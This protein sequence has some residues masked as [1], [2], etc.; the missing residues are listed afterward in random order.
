MDKSWMKLQRYDQRYFDGINN[1]IDFVRQNRP[2]T[3]HLCACTRCRLHHRKL[4]LDQTYAHLIQNGMMMDYTTWTE[5]GKVRTN[6]SI[7]MLRQQYIMEKSGEYVS[8]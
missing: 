7:Y 2:E 3:T 6:P 1:F 5:Q 8:Q 4:T